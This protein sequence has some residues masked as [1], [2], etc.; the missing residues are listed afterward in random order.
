MTHENIKFL[1]SAVPEFSIAAAA[2]I[3]RVNFG[4]VGEFKAL[5]SERDQN[6]RIRRHDG[7]DFLLKIANSHE[8]PAVLDMQHKALAHSERQDPALPSPRA[9]PTGDRETIC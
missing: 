5:Y 8:D 7:V 3:A 9:I 6:F 4:V 1:D 2:E